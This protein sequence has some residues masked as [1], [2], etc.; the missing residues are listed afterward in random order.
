MPDLPWTTNQLRKLGICI[1]D[2]K[3]IPESLPTYDAVMVY[4]NDVAADT[5]SKIKALDWTPLLGERIPE[6]TSR[7]K[8]IDT[9]REKLQRDHSTPLQSVQDIAGVRFEAEMTLDEQDG[10]ANA[11][12]GLFGHDLQ[13]CCRDM[14]D[15]PHSGYRALHLWLK[16]PARV[17]VQIRTHLQGR[18]ANTY[19]AAADVLGRGIRYDELPTDDREK[20]F[21]VDLQ[22][23]STSGLSTLER[24]RSKVRTLRSLEEA[25]EQPSKSKLREFTKAERDMD[26]TE[27]VVLEGLANLKA[28]FDTMRLTRKD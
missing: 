11:I 23:I 19:E 8:T 10:V 6:V 20:K 25:K 1:R 3:P 18:W 13:V 26:E 4:Y 7:P 14:R 9:L 16:L 17:E 12:A 24:R 28:S 21:V 2:S 27:N 5:Q 22:D 15:S